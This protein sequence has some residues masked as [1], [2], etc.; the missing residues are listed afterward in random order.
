[1]FTVNLI[2]H[3]SSHRWLTVGGGGGGLV[4]PTLTPKVNTSAHDAMI[5]RVGGTEVITQR[6]FR[7]VHPVTL[8]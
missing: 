5:K 6:R 4:R 2:F 1:M 7:G 3:V 8:H